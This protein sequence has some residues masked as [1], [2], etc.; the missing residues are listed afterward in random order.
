MYPRGE[1]DIDVGVGCSAFFSVVKKRGSFGWLLCDY[2]SRTSALV[3]DD[4]ITG[5]V[6]FVSAW[7]RSGST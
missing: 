5:Y 2:A 7:G 4:S 3:H 1:V 6:S